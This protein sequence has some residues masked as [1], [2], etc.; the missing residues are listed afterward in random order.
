MP[1][2]SKRPSWSDSETTFV[3]NAFGELGV[4]Y[5]SRL[6][7]RLPAG[8]IAEYRALAT[9]YQSAV[10]GKPVR[11][12]QQKSSTV[13]LATAISEAVRDAGA[14]RNAVRQG[15]SDKAIH[16]L[17]GVGQDSN[18]KT[19]NK[20]LASWDVVIEAMEARSNDLHLFGITSDDLAQA[21]ASRQRI[22]DIDL[23]QEAAKGK[24]LSA[25]ASKL[26]LHHRLIAMSRRLLGAAEIEF[27][28][29]PEI[30]A[31]FRSPIPPSGRRKKQVVA[32]V[33][34]A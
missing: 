21:K 3:V 24:K 20:A 11:L 29:E 16:R 6:A 2:K 22:I 28:A 13:A 23:E 7:P 33:S 25:S 31:R 18:G 12:S 14:I 8:F 15:T 19:V 1:I 32:P 27:R 34:P 5:E 30:L 10:A 17:F 9:Q 4:E 26:A